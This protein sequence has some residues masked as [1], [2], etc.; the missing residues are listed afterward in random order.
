MARYRIISLE[1]PVRD[2]KVLRMEPDNAQA[3]VDLGDIRQKQADDIRGTN[4]AATTTSKL[5]QAKSL[6][7]EARSHYARALS[8]ASL[9]GYAGAKTEYVEKQLQAVDRELFVRE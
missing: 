8:D 9:K 2:M 6:Y 4:L 7:E 5:K 1:T 3:H